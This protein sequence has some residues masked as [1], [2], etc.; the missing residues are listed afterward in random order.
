[1][2]DRTAAV[3]IAAAS[4]GLVANP[5]SSGTRARA[6]RAL[7]RNH[8]LG[9]YSRKSDAAC[10][11]C[12]TYAANTT[13]WQFPTCPVIPAYWRAI[14]TVAVPFFQLGG[15]VQRQDRLRVAEP[16]G[17]ELLQR[18]QRRF[19]VPDVLGRQSLHP[20]RRAV[21]GRLRQ[22]PARLSVTRLGQQR[23]DAGE[24]RKPRPGLHVRPC[25]QRKQLPPQFPRP[26]PVTYD[27]IGG[28]LVVQGSH[29]P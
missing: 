18:G 16:R 29:K 26:R 19:P 27:G 15:L 24:R 23:A 28:H 3:T 11:R 4:A 2:H 12:V 5:V 6:R 13:V 20:P 14:P 22:L 17:D 9:R 1:M 8:D 21:P 25:Q 7:P 10:A